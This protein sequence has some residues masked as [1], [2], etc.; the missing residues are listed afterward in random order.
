IM[1]AAATVTVTSF[2]NAG[3][4]REVF[5]HTR[6]TPIA[7]LTVSSRSTGIYSA[8][9][10]IREA[11]NIVRRYDPS[12]TVVVVYERM[13]LEWRRLMYYLPEFRIIGLDSQSNKYY[14]DA[15]WHVMDTPHSADV[16]LDR[17]IT[18]ILF[19]GFEPELAGGEIKPELNREGHLEFV[20]TETPEG[21]SFRIGLYRFVRV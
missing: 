11:I 7:S 19:F 14:Y 5:L 4:F 6:P 2:L 16:P 8:D 10:D 17:R 3:I 1:L 21:T 12:T 18:T 20:E 15:R 13:G 9:E